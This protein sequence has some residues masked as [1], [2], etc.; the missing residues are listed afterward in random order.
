MPDIDV[1]FSDK[2]RDQV[3]NYVRKKYGEDHVAQICTFGTIAARAAVKDVGKVLGIPFAEMNTI[4]KLMPNK[5]G[6]KIHECLDESVEFKKL[7]DT[8]ERIRKVIDSAIR[9]EG[10]IRQL[11]VHACAVIIA[12]EPITNYCALQHPPKDTTTIISQLS[13]YPLEELGLLKMDFLGLRNLTIIHRCLK[14]IQKNHGLF[15]DLLK[16]DYEDRKVFKVFAE[17]DT[18]GVFQFE[19]SGMRKYLRE[20]KP[21][22]FEDLIAMASLYRPGPLQYIPTYI[23]RKHGR[24]K[25][26][27]PHPSLENILRPTQGIAVYQE[28]IMQLVQAFAGFSL[29]EADILRR[30]IGKKKID[31]LMEQ[32]EKFIKAAVAQGNTEELAK[33]IFED[34]I[35]PFAGYGFNKSHAAC[36]AMIAYQ[37]AFLKAN[38]PTEF[39]TALMVSDEDDMERITMEIAECESRGIKILPPDVNESL[40]H[41]TYI[42]VHSIRFGLK[43]IKGLG[44]GP[45]QAII[46]G[47]SRSETKYATIL[48]FVKKNATEVINK[49]SLESLILSGSL[50]SFGERASLIASIPKIIALARENAHQN[51]TRQIGL[52]DM[53]SSASDDF[54]VDLEKVTPMS[55]EEKIKGEK[56]IIGYSVSG[57]ALDGLKR[58]VEKRTQGKQH[59]LA[60]RRTLAERVE[61]SDLAL[62]HEDSGDHPAP[63]T[64]PKTPAS[65][66]SDESNLPAEE[67][68]STPTPQQKVRKKETR[69]CFVGLA[70]NV[71]HVQTKAGKM[72]II[73]T[74]E[75]FDFRFTTV[76]FPKDYEQYNKIIEVDKILLVEGFLKTNLEMG[77]ISVAVSAVKASTIT[78]IRNQAIEMGLFHEQ[79][80]VNLFSAEESML[81]EPTS[82]SSQEKKESIS[83]DSSPK[84]QERTFQVPPH[85]KKEDLLACK[86]YLE[87]LPR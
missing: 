68:P 21:T 24:E 64:A 75:S 35:E 26:K 3:L 50:D 23:A 65:S 8:D 4:T 78:A 77:E 58:Y 13:Q 79:D 9:L 10:S 54:R 73:A 70:T 49:K 82:H 53:G 29:G 83:H 48:D 42:D 18:T 86:A 12:P 38:Y 85:A 56:D 36:Y 63:T 87:T 39:M 33:Y 5:P 15:I 19:S 2:G 37:T 84:P 59:V 47:R 30:A 45:I 76:V 11:G 40:K 14:I 22:V 43:A 17:G 80:K 28:Q 7:Y 52:F 20:L 74:C 62:A 55:Y 1:D 60:F 27:Y 44:D 81:A 72:M 25:V 51:T 41:F 67:E 71:R 46:Q 57:H 61:E 66:Q 32:K 31:L 6:I 69:V 16:I 34:I